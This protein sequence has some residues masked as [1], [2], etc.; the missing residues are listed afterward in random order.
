MVK[1]RLG[2]LPQS[3]GKLLLALEGTNRAGLTYNRGM[4]ARTAKIALSLVGAAFIVAVT[5][6]EGADFKLTEANETCANAHALL[7]ASKSGKHDYIWRRI[8]HVVRKKPYTYRV[9]DDYEP[10]VMYKVS[11]KQYDTKYVQGGSAY[12]AHCG[13]GGT[14][15]SLARAFFDE[16]PKWGSVTVYCG[17]V[18]HVL[19]N[20]QR[21]TLPN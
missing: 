14:C 20:G 18:P 10:G 11:F 6:A 1:Q 3:G 21:V 12:V 7:V 9:V 15:N 19:D 17:L 8:A 5:P 4:L 13:H 2:L 16:H